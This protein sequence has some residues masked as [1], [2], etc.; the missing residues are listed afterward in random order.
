MK[1]IPD[2]HK[3]ILAMGIDNK[4]PDAVA[5][6]TVPSLNGT[7]RFRYAIVPR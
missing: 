1:W 2:T 6:V 3:W 5:F 7:K 4:Y